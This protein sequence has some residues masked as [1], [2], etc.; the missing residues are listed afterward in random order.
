MK[1]EIAVCFFAI[2]FSPK[3]QYLNEAAMACHHILVLMCHVPT[4]TLLAGCD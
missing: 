1:I 2:A 3:E 4:G